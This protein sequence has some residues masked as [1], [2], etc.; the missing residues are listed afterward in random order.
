MQDG[1]A[2]NPGMLAVLDGE[3]PMAAHRRRRRKILQRLS[4]RCARQQECFGLKPRPASETHF[5]RGCLGRD[6]NMRHCLASYTA[7]RWQLD[8]H[9]ILPPMH[10]AISSIWLIGASA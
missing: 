4:R 2:A 1:E 10:R 9:I 5:K 3:G 7:P 6:E 8:L